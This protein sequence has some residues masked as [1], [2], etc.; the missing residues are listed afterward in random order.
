MKDARE[1]INS[2]GGQDGARRC[3]SA[4]LFL[5]FL[6]RPAKRLLSV[7]SIHPSMQQILFEHLLR[8]RRWTRCQDNLS[9]GLGRTPLE[10]GHP[11]KNIDAHRA[12]FP[13]GK[14][15]NVIDHFP[16]FI[17]KEFGRGRAGTQ[18][19]GVPVVRLLHWPCELGKPLNLSELS[20]RV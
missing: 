19:A 5:R 6:L 2:V 18:A 10:A 9:H 1:N 3:F 13:F 4:S 8:T 17:D 11:L 14:T 15:L 20:F 12:L 7:L 16:H